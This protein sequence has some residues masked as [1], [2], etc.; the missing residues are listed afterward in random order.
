MKKEKASDV[1]NI[2]KDL[3]KE[4]E[5]M[6]K[7]EKEK[8]NVGLLLKE[9]IDGL[10]S[11]VAAFSQSQMKDE[12]RKQ[13]VGYLKNIGLNL[14]DV[15][16]T[17]KIGDALPPQPYEFGIEGKRNDLK[18]FLEKKKKGRIKKEKRELEVQSEQKPEI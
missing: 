14:L 7:S 8:Y 15:C 10:R 16:K 17:L 1:L 12:T 5:I 3:R 13:K 11:C 9:S 2:I 6:E 4:T 18:K